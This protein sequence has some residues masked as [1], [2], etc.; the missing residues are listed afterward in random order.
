M[1][2]VLIIDRSKHY[3]EITKIKEIMRFYSD[4]T[5]LTTLLIGKETYPNP[6]HIVGMQYSLLADYFD[7]HEI[8]SFLDN[9]RYIPFHYQKR[10]PTFYTYQTKNNY[11][12]NI[13]FIEEKN[14]DYL[15]LISGPMLSELPSAN[16]MKALT[17]NLQIMSKE[18][19]AIVRTLYCLPKF[20]YTHIN[21]IGKLF[22]MLVNTNLTSLDQIE[23]IR[24]GNIPAITSED[25]N[26]IDEKDYDLNNIFEFL[27]RIGD[28]IIHGN[29][30]KIIDTVNEN[31]ALLDHL[32]T[33]YDD[34]H[35]LKYFCV[36]ICTI[37]YCYALN[38]DVSFELLFKKLWGFV[39]NLDKLHSINDIIHLMSLTLKEYSQTVYM[40]NKIFSP[41]VN[42]ILRYISIHYAE[43]ITLDDLSKELHLTPVYIS[44]IIKKD[45]KISL[46][47]HINL[48][49]IKRSKALLS[50]SNQSIGEI[51]FSVGYNYQ[52][53][54]TKVFQKY[55][56]M[57]PREYRFATK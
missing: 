50:Y 26:V 22:L 29:Y 23:Q 10:R 19:K 4:L 39:I 9:Y 24:N 53:H 21:S 38:S 37:S 43:K 33:K 49:R 40:S 20:S 27:I 18:K 6:L 17:N 15:V 7:V 45:T 32:I 54:F 1:T 41:H 47:D 52:S 35:S 5:R 51:A 12:Y 46:S 48:T 57:T 28:N 36:I 55:E 14:K 34:Y 44:Y 2:N 56:G 3:M 42:Q 30:T 31:L 13:L 25:T 11:I 8:L 16:Q